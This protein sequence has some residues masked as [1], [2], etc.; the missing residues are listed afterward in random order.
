MA[1]LPLRRYSKL[2][3][4]K[5]YGAQMNYAR[6][7]DARRA[8]VARARALTATRPGGFHP[9]G[10][11]NHERKYFDIASG[12]VKINATGSVSLICI[13]TLGSDFN[14]RIGRK[15]QIRS[16]YLRMRALITAA[17]DMSQVAVA[18][19]VGRIMLVVDA[20]PNG[21]LPSITDILVG[22]NVQSHLNADNRDRFS[23]IMDKELVFDAYQYGAGASAGWARTIHY[24]KKYKKTNTQVIF[25]GTN[26]GTIGDIMSGAVYLVMLGN[27][28]SGQTDITAH[29]STRVRFDD[30]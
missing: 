16:I 6:R 5:R 7:A 19:Q 29:V 8:A 24:V 28:V 23:I 12:S 11:L 18:P 20:Q 30:M 21:T 1:P 9:V 26:G 15:I 2:R 27:H 13:P 25:N 4:F 17:E 14:N 10:P 22:N 3:T